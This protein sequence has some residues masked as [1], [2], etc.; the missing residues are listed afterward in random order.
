MAQ[1]LSISALPFQEKGTRAGSYL[2]LLLAVEGGLYSPPTFVR[3]FVGCASCILGINFNG[4]LRTRVSSI[5]Q[6]LSRCWRLLRH[7]EA[8]EQLRDT[9]SKAWAACNRDWEISAFLQTM[10]YERGRKQVN[11]RFVCSAYRVEPQSCDIRREP[12]L[13][14]DAIAPS[15]E[16]Q[17]SID[18][19][20]PTMCRLPGPDTVH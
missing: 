20:T 15:L 3:S 7:V 4:E 14:P 18:T 19:N 9:C 13:R 17:P 10:I 8:V 5:R 16:F 11:S 1:E 6:L 2:F 12:I